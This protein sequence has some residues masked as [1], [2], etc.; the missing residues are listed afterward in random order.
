MCF[1]LFQN[2][3]LII[4][5][6]QVFSGLIPAFVS[7]FFTSIVVSDS[8]ISKYDFMLDP[9]DRMASFYPVELTTSTLGA[10][11]YVS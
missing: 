3:F 7:D 10:S 1:K 2:C 6:L 9:S 8:N 4:I 11:F 5:A